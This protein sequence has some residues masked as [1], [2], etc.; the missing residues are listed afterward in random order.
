M[1][2]NIPKNSTQHTA[3]KLLKAILIGLFWG[4][5]VLYLSPIIKDKCLQIATNDPEE[6]S[7]LVTFLCVFVVIL[8][9][10]CLM[11]IKFHSLDQKL[12]SDINKR[13]LDNFNNS[14][15]FLLKNEKSNK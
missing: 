8:L 6:I 14:I 10:F 4:V 5:L 11:M 9:S 12:I 13:S 3:K 2:T 7:N 1:T 15:N